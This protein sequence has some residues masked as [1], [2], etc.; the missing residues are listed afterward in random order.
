MRM[1]ITTGITLPRI[2]RR[3]CH[4]ALTYAIVLFF[5][6]ATNLAQ[7]ES[8]SVH[9]HF[10]SPSGAVSSTPGSI[11]SAG[12]IV[13]F[14]TDAAAVLHGFLRETTGKILPLDPP[15]STFTVA[16]A[17]TPAGDVM[18]YYQ[19]AG[20]A[21]HGFVSNST[22]LY[23]SFDAAP[24]SLGTVPLAMNRFG[25][26]AGYFIDGQA[27]FH[28]LLRK[29]DATFVSFEACHGSNTIAT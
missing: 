8:T 20:K 9:F 5:L 2:R 6:G 29:T 25:S 19:D 26:I 10:F 18:G 13:G 23:V 3:R 21:T 28:G 12:Q 16:R 15:G 11:D 7:N 22:G 14:Y 17:S 1:M 27:S 24:G 4:S